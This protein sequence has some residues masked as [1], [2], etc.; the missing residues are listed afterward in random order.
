MKIHKIIPLTLTIFSLILAACDFNNGLNNSFGLTGNGTSNPSDDTVSYSSTIVS[1]NDSL[2]ASNQFSDSS[3]TSI[4]KPQYNLHPIST[5]IMSLYARTIIGTYVEP[6]PSFTVASLYDYYNK[7]PEDWH[8]FQENKMTYNLAAEN[9][10]RCYYVSKEVRDAVD[11]ILTVVGRT[12]GIPWRNL[13]AYIYGYNYGKGSSAFSEELVNQPIMEAILPDKTTYIDEIVDGYYFLDIVRYFN[14]LDYEG[15]S[16]VDFVHYQFK[17]N[18]IKID[19]SEFIKTYRCLVCRFSDANVRREG[20]M[21]QYFSSVDYGAGIE[22]LTKDNKEALRDKRFVRKTNS[23]THYYDRLDECII[24]QT[25][26]ERSLSGDVYDIT[27]DY[28]KAMNLLEL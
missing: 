1:N 19:N 21:F 24:E 15:F 12:N 11:T 18:R 5:D 23:D 7:Y 6:G 13:N 27:F 14:D 9:K 28:Q 22:I 26:V 25:Y 3:V 4:E 17:D 20:C 8:L 10:I 2:S 16:F